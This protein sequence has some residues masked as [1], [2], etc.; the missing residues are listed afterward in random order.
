MESELYDYVEAKAR[1]G[2]PESV[3]EAIDEFSREHEGLYHLGP[4]KGEFLDDACR[5]A[6]PNR[7][8][9]L[10]S[11]FGYSAVRMARFLGVGGE[12]IAIEANR[13]A[14]ER[15]RAMVE[16]GG[17]AD[18][19]QVVHATG[20]EAIPELTGEFDLVFIDHGSSSYLPDLLELERREL[21]A[22]NAILVADNIG[23]SG[24]AVGDY[25]EHVRTSGK[26]RSELH[27]S[28]LHNG[29]PFADGV[30]VSERL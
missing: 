13:D 9:E 28:E 15:V 3:L 30:E 25:V 17:V 18:R 16:L 23:Y 8:V 27:R 20:E 7:I 26:Y 2:D 21:L 11:L 19:V 5:R 6:E 12:L 1:T 14:V 29:R 10:G 4:E 24:D 22:P